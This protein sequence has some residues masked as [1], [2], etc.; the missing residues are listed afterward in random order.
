MK[1]T[2]ITAVENLL[3]VDIDPSFHTQVEGWIEAMSRYCDRISNRILFRDEAETYT[4]DGN[5]QK[6][7]L[8]D[9]CCEIS[10]V[11]VHGNEVLDE[12]HQYPQ[13]KNY[14]SRLYYENIFPQGKGNV[15]VTGIQAMHSELPED[16]K[17]ACTVLVAG[18]C[19]N[20]LLEQKG[21]KTEK[22]GNY[23]VTYNTPEE[24]A[25]TITAK[26]TL[27]SYRRIAI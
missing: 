16:I 9:D 23:S 8:I 12:I 4:Y 1:Y 26:N 22:I 5:N 20:Q 6:I 17:Y 19:R 14:A 13:N 10:S 2:D 7:L 27:S 24:E 25:A 15:S 11:L 18:I 21:G 3:L